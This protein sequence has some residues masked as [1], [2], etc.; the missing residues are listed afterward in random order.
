MRG[1]KVNWRGGVDEGEDEGKIG[2]GRQIRDGRKK[3]RN[4]SEAG[5]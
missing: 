3:G 1:K 5:E 4:S 2:K